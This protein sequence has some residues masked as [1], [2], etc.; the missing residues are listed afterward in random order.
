LRTKKKKPNR[1]RIPEKRNHGG[2]FWKGRRG[3]KTVKQQE[4]KTVSQPGQ[5]VLTKERKRQRGMGKNDTPKS[6][7][8]EKRTPQSKKTRANVIELHAGK[9][10]KRKKKHM[11]KNHSTFGERKKKKG[12]KRE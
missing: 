12:T 8:S 10:K 9:K 4:R 11:I 6:S 5:K 3:K 7:K 1:K 2:V